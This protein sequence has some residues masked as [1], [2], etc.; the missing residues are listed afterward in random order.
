MVL[1]QIPSALA[2]VSHFLVSTVSCELVVESLPN[3]HGYII[4]TQQRNWSD[5][6]DLDLIFMVIAV[7]KLKICDEGTFVFS[8]NNLTSFSQ[9][10]G[11]VIFLISQ[12]KHIFCGEIRKLFI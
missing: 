9:N 7:E 1:V 11:I 2:L 12:Q 5:F 3:F 4:G 8:E 10:C 6:D